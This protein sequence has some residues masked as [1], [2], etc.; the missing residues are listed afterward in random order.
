MPRS[1]SIPFLPAVI[2][3]LCTGGPASAQV[4]I[5]T[6]GVVQ[7]GPV[8]APMAG[9]ELEVPDGFAGR[10]DEDAAGV[11]LESREGMFM[12]L[13]GWSE[14]DVEEVAA[15]VE[16]RLAAL[17]LRLQ[18]A[19]APILTDTELRGVFDAW[20]EEGRGILAAGIRRGA[21]GN[22]FA[23]A[24]LG[25]PDAR[26]AVERTRDDVIESLRLTRPGAA[27]W[28][29]EVEGTVLRWSSSGSDMSS[30]TTTA[31]GASSSEASIGLCGGSM[32][33]Y[34]E[35]SE[36]FVS[37]EGMS[38]SSESSDGHAGRWWITADLAGQAMLTLEASDGRVFYW[39]VEEAGDGVLVDGYR[40]VP[41]GRC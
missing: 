39:S 36:S 28:R 11:V 19:D 24:V 25:G 29:S 3:M 20:S 35:S 27:G 40:Y 5:T 37:I 6:S 22:V 2:L 34:V 41:T 13:W 14:G 7:A 17:G 8:A 38:A 23:V 33:R 4:P 32:Y 30:G 18:E 26:A 9:I 1:G 21:E 12:G 15:A 16:G 10:W 31:T